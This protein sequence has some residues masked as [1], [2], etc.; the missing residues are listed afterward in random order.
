[1]AVV[2]GALL[3]GRR[4]RR[5]SPRGLGRESHTRPCGRRLRAARGAPWLKS[6]ARPA[7][8]GLRSCLICRL[9]ARSGVAQP[10]QPQRL[11]EV[12]HP[13]PCRAR[14]RHAGPPEGRQAD[15]A[16]LPLANES[17]WLISPPPLPPPPP[18]LPPPPPPPPPPPGGDGSRGIACS[19]ERLQNLTDSAATSV[20]ASVTARAT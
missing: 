18:P 6:V 12:S 3:R 10:A 11:G 20:H 2:G 19:S 7:F 13:F 17:A 9:V 4:Q 14:F 15:T 5:G 8:L 16:A 1:M